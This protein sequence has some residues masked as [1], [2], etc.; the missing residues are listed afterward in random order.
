[1]KKLALD[2]ESLAVES[3]DPQPTDAAGRP[4]TV[5]AHD[6][7]AAEMIVSQPVSNCLPSAC[8]TCGI[9]C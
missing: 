4:G 1:M 2:L 8:A 3:F 7:A 9:Y 6:A 5:R